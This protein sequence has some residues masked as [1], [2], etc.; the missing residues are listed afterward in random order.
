MPSSCSDF[1][2][3]RGSGQKVVSYSFFGDSK[4]ET[5]N[6]R[7]FS[8]IEARAREVRRLYPGWIMRLYFDLEEDDMDAVKAMCELWCSHDHIDF[9]DVTSLPKPFGNL[10]SWQPV[11]EYE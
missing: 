11:G 8:Q 4:E 3:S 6:K 10:K 1:S 5:V 7:F 9:C 2:T